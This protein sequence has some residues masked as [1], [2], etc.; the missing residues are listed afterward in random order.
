MLRS[1]RIAAR[2]PATGGIVT[3]ATWTLTALAALALAYVIYLLWPRW[4]ETAT[5]ADAPSLPI[6]I[7]DV[8]F[9]VPPHA[10]RQKVQRRAGVQERVD[11]VYAWPTLEPAAI[12]P[13]PEAGR[14]P[15]PPDRLF[16]T[17][18]TAPSALTPEERM[19]TVYPRYTETIAMKGPDGL[20][21]LPFRADT[22]YHG[23]DLLYDPQAPD[24]FAV[25][26]TRDKG[27]VPGMCIYERFFG[28]ADVSF[29]V[30][31]A[32]LGEWRGV[33]ASIDRVIEQLQPANR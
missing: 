2:A 24:H 7:G 17:I 9:N 16:I 21:L 11:L 27:P 6:V 15:L 22:P 12:L 31:R 3:L 14:A 8:F 26:C 1:A 29:R 13:K 10:I 18:A 33:L 23:E 4:P 19:K 5:S 28:K 20:S 25:R 32:W 30:P